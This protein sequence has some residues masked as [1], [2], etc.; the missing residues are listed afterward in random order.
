MFSK[1]G[2]AQPDS[3][4]QELVIWHLI[5]IILLHG[6]LDMRYSINFS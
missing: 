4:T 1:T 6:H 5:M 3:K 2:Q